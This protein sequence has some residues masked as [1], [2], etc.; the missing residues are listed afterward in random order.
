MYKKKKQYRLPN[1]DYSRFGWYFV[2]ICTKG[3]KH[4]F[5]DIEKGRLCLSEI[6]RI[7]HE[8]WLNTGKLRKNVYLDAFTVMPNHVHGIIGIIDDSCLAFCRN[9]PRRV[10]TDAMGVRNISNVSTEQGMPKIITPRRVPTEKY[11]RPVTGKHICNEDTNWGMI[12][13]M[14]KNS[15]SSMVNHFKGAVTRWCNKNGHPHFGWQRRFND[16]IIWDEGSLW[17][18]RTYIENNPQNWKEDRNNLNIIG[19]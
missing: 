10:P 4:W 3:R 17:A 12:G 8:E 7:A 15:L 2:T 16:R 18:A 1:Y 19:K 14:T 5:G 11:G 9:T 6:G 13:P